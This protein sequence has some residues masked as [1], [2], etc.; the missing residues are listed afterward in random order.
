MR[1][2]LQ[3]SRCIADTLTSLAEEAEKLRD[4]VRAKD[5]E[6]RTAEDAIAGHRGDNLEF[7]KE[8][9]ALQ[10][11]TARLEDELADARRIQDLLDDQKQENL[12][13]K[14][15]ID[16]LRFDMDEMRM[17]SNHLSVDSSGA[18]DGRLSVA[19]SLSRNLG[20]ELAR[21]LSEEP[22]D[23][24]V[25]AKSDDEKTEGG[26]SVDEVI[27]T[28]HRLIKKHKKAVAVSS[29][30]G[31]PVIT[32][33]EEVT[34]V[35]DANVQT[36]EVETR[37]GSAQTELGHKDVAHE[38]TAQLNGRDQAQRELADSLGVEVQTLKSFFDQRNVHDGSPNIMRINETLASVGRMLETRDA[39]AR[40]RNR[41]ATRFQR[42]SS[43]PPFVFAIMPKAA[44]PFVDKI[45][46]NS[47]TL[48]LWSLVV[49][50][51]GVLTGFWMFP[52]HKLPFHLLVPQSVD[53]AHWLQYNTLGTS[54]GEGFGT[55]DIVGYGG[56]RSH[57]WGWVNEYVP[58]LWLSCA[59]ADLGAITVSS[60]A[61][62]RL[63]GASLSKASAI[64]Y[65]SVA[66]RLASLPY[67]VPSAVRR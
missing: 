29:A 54:W 33:R 58:V 6:L 18:S 27:V 19:P 49:Y 30:P 26:D 3:R 48:V 44:Q 28:H 7:E 10:A 37:D 66:L 52:S 64:I 23:K 61:L 60:G 47:T 24:D 21:R 4:L 53:Q 20:R 41:L 15:T 5:Q 31:E 51:S 8:R 2:R 57:L 35:S 9:Q 45:A 62:S 11:A 55:V 42:A 22:G 50:L 40:R 36:D 25:E 32:H 67:P 63:P 38:L 59:R 17:S 39:P 43:T 46:Q 34:V 13:L 1:D 16:R 65:Y 12:V 56:A 14:E